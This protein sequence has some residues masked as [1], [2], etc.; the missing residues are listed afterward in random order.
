[1]SSAAE[2]WVEEVARTTRPDTIHW[3]DGSDAENQQLIQLLV[4]KGELTKLNDK[5]LPNSY[6]SRSDKS[7][8]ARTERLTF[9]V[10]DKPEQVG[11]TNNW[12]SREDAQARVWPLFEGCM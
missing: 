4:S 11:P 7:D 12:M 5:V 9:I 10:A 6:L 3:C 8:V 2:Q 1:M